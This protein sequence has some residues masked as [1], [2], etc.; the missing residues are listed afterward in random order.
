MSNHPPDIY[1]DQSNGRSPEIQ[2]QQQ[3]L[4]RQSSRPF[5]AYGGMSTGDMFNP[6]DPA[7][8]YQLNPN[9]YDRVDGTP[10]PGAFGNE[11]YQS[12]SWNP[13]AFNNNQYSAAYAATTRIRPQQM[14]GRQPLPNVS[15][16]QGFQDF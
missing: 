3:M 2:R 16:V 15:D 1:F 13:Q 10:A 5:D 4:H 7:N 6:Q 12:Q 11:I 9:R 14:R 8:R